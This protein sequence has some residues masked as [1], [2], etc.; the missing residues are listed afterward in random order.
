MAD[1]PGS[2]DTADIGTPDDGGG[3]DINRD[4]PI[5]EPPTCD[6]PK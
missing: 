6:P 4:T 1:L 5:C 3:L 2:G